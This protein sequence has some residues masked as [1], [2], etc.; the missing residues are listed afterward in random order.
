MT[1]DQNYFTLGAIL[2][3]SF[4][5]LDFCS[6]LEMFGNLKPKIEQYLPKHATCRHLNR[7]VEYF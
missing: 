1:S 6:P 3:D 5:L 4:E 7:I 2:S